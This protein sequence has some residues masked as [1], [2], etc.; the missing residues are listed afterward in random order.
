MIRKNWRRV[1]RRFCQGWY[2][3]ARDWGKFFR[4]NDD[5]CPPLF[6]LSSLSR[7]LI[8]RSLLPSSFCSLLFLSYAQ[9]QMSQRASSGPLNDDWQRVNEKSIPPSFAQQPGGPLSIN[10]C[11]SS[12]LSL[13]FSPPSPATNS[14]PK[15]SLS[16]LSLRSPVCSLLPYPFFYT[17]LYLRLFCAQHWLKI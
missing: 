12:L 13:L 6:L 1:N 9:I 3:M 4:N 8:I 15:F 17:Y 10:M 16:S 14:L 11:I 5:F 2:E 7:P